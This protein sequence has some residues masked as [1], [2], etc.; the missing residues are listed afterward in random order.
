MTRKQFYA[1]CMSLLIDP[2]IA[3]ENHKIRMALFDRDA[4]LVEFLL[5][6]EF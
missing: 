1:L 4:A 5:K 3:I 6:T 2:A